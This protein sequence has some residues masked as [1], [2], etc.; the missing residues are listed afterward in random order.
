MNACIIN[1]VFPVFESF[2]QEVEWVDRQ[3]GYI[4]ALLSAYNLHK[5][6]HFIESSVD[7]IFKKNKCTV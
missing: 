5:I 2:P 3:T 4:K 6:K 7:P 1:A